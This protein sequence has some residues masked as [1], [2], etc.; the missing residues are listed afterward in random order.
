MPN[1]RDAA[2]RIRQ[3]DP[4]VRRPCAWRIRN[5]IREGARDV[6]RDQVLPREDI[7]EADLVVYRRRHEEVAR[8]V[9]FLESVKIEV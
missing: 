9:Q 5:R 4:E 8:Q 6:A 2:L 1:A 3:D 7:R